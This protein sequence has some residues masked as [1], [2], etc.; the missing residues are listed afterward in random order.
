MRVR[1]AVGG[2]DAISLS[3]WLLALPVAVATALPIGLADSAGD[4]VA[5]CVLGLASHQVA[6]LVL[7]FAWLTYLGPGE[8]RSRPVAAVITFAVAG[9]VAGVTAGGLTWLT[10]IST[11]AQFAWRIPASAITLVVWCGLSAV[12]VTSVRQLRRSRGELLRQLA[13]ERTLAERSAEV[14]AEHRRRIVEETEEKV[15]EQ[16]RKAVEASADPAAAAAQLTQVVD[17][18]VRPLSHELRRTEVDEQ[19]LVDSVQSVGAPPRVPWTYYLRGAA[20]VSP[21]SPAAAALVVMVSP[22]DPPA[23]PTDW[24]QRILGILAGGIAVFLLM[25]LAR[26]LLERRLARLRTATR[27]FFELGIWLLVAVAYVAASSLIFEHPTSSVRTLVVGVILAWYAL[28]VASAVVA[29]VRQE[30]RTDENLRHAVEAAEWAAARLRQLAWSEQQQLGRIMHGD[31]QARIVSLALQIQMNADTDVPGAVARL[32]DDVHVLLS[33]RT[34]EDSW[35]SMLDQVESLWQYSLDLM[36][37]IPPEAATALDRDPVA[38]HAFVEVVRESITNAVRHGRARSV[39]VTTTADVG[40]IDLIVED[41]GDPDVARGWP[42]LGS[43]TMDVACLEWDFVAT[44]SGH[45]LTAAIP[46]GADDD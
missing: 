30:P 14:V 15:A 1:A 3:G 18:V 37:E 2:R 41:D 31:A 43:R 17:E 6:G 5:L 27:V 39:L 7:I 20:E 10:G 38:A 21:F 34:S 33:V 32:S 22:L 40:R 23:D 35:R 24:L 29:T 26:L 45:R 46:C 44:T 19:R 28:C 36:V 4:L 42:G 12:L 9:A 16:L 13:R 25:F 8:R 11:D